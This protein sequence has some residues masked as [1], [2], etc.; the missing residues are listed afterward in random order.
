MIVM[1]LYCRL[2][3]SPRTNCCSPMS[4]CVDATCFVLCDH[5]ASISNVPSQK[6]RAPFPRAAT[7]LMLYLSTYAVFVTPI[8]LHH[9][10]CLLRVLLF[11]QDALLHKLLGTWPT[12][13]TLLQVVSPHVQ[14]ELSLVSLERRSSGRVGQNVAL[15]EV[16]AGRAL[17]QAL[18]EVVCGALAFELQGFGLEGTVCDCQLM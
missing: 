5:D 11:L 6:R 18:A 14:V 7:E 17:V 1:C 8:L 4:D 15:D 3:S 10:L 16:V 9:S 13:E 12:L 2:S